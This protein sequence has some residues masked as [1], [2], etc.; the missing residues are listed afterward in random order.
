MGMND[1]INSCLNSVF[2]IQRYVV[3]NSALMRPNETLATQAFQSLRLI[4]VEV[5]SMNES[6]LFFQK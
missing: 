6:L 5:L 1:R 4:I 3:N 2:I